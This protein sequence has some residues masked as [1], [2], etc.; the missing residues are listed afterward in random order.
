MTTHPSVRLAALVSVFAFIGAGCAKPV[1]PTPLPSP[2]NPAGQTGGSVQSPELG[3]GKLPMPAIASASANFAGGNLHIANSSGPEASVTQDTSGAVAMMPNFV[4]GS[5]IA[6]PGRATPAMPPTLMPPPNLH[7]ATVEYLIDK[8]MPSWNT[9]GDVLQV[10]HAL[11]DAGTA[12]AFAQNAGL[13]P[14]A[15]SSD[16]T[17]S[18]ITLQWID[19]EQYQWSFD[20]RSR[21][22]SFWSQKEGQV[23]TSTK[24]SPDKDAAIAAANAFLDAHGFSSISQSGASVDD[25]QWNMLMGT[26][27]NSGSAKDVIYPC[28][29]MGSGANSGSGGASVGIMNSA[30]AV[31][32]SAI[33][34]P[35]KPGMP[36]IPPCG[37]WSQPITVY[38][39][40]T[41]DGKPV[42]DAYGNPFRA[43]SVSVNVS[44]NEVMNG[45]L[46]LD[47]NVNHASYPFIDKDTATKRLQ[48]GG[49]NPVSQWAYNGARNI[50]VHLTQLDIVWMRYDS[51]EEGD[52][53]TY[54]LPALRATGTTDYG[55]KGQTPQPYTTLVPLVADSAFADTGTS[56]SPP[57]TPAPL[58]AVSGGMPIKGA[59][60]PQSMP[61]SGPNVY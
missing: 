2:Q 11:P 22:V 3:F 43:N 34:M 20:V 61:G 19:P 4:S 32:S 28:P 46:Q 38:Y 60:E 24:P 5:G 1:Q 39:G 16:S 35:I 41:R 30:K 14:Q 10:E 31:A 40:G 8:A 7:P 48:A 26:A 9:S 15:L 36:S 55:I 27:G 13:P 12:S 17:I 47:E 59:P 33:A 29:M 37:G 42:T 56:T 45:N 50:T 6:I 49:L 21:S 54:Y 23:D 53:Q 57:P 44:S 25:T 18:S 58:P 52:N 51:W